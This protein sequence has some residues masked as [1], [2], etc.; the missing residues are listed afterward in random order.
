MSQITSTG[1]GRFIRAAAH[2][3]WA[4]ALPRFVSLMDDKR[5]VRRVGQL[6]ADAERSPYG[7]KIVDDHHWLEV[8]LGWQSAVLAETGKLPPSLVALRS[9][10]ALMFASTVVDL[11]N[12]LGAFGRRV[13]RGRLRD[14]LNTGFAGLFLELSLAS[15]LLDADCEVGFPDFEGRANYDL[16]VICGETELVPG[17]SVTETSKSH[18]S[19]FRRAQSAG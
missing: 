6:I 2:E 11:A 10:A 9:A 18:A 16:D 17:T 7:A 3:D 5:W 19:R 15:M 12:S 8:E 14:G 4:V 1:N 13:L